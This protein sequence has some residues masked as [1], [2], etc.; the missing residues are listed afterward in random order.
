M[1]EKKA[2]LTSHI[3]SADSW[4]LLPK[5]ASIVAS[6][7]PL[8]WWISISPA[9]ALLHRRMESQKTYEWIFETGR[10]S[11]FMISCNFIA[12]VFWKVNLLFATIPMN[13]P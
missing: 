5:R 13:Q 8:E 6:A 11:R 1:S 9:L 12:T 10:L 4:L 7:P 2:S 3:Y